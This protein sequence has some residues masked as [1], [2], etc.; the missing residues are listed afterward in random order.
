VQV[1]DQVFAAPRLIAQKVLHIGDGL[2]GD[3]AAFPEGGALTATSF[4][5]GSSG[6]AGFL[7]GLIRVR[8]MRASFAAAPGVSPAAVNYVAKQRRPLPNSLEI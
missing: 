1:F 2:I 4:L 6:H 5:S 3:L 7:L 8:L